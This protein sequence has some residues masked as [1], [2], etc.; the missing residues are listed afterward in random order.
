MKSPVATEIKA[1]RIY[2]SQRNIFIQIFNNY[3]NY[4]YILLYI[5]LP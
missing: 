1:G 2:E 5:E 4:F 3:S